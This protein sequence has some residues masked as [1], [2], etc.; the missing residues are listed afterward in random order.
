M[1]CDGER[2]VNAQHQ[3]GLTFSAS[4]AIRPPL[5]TD[6]PRGAIAVPDGT[7]CQYRTTEKTLLAPWNNFG[8]GGGGGK[9]WVHLGAR[10]VAAFFAS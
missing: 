5:A 2:K 9:L 8:T 10:T 3:A 6:M 7:D 4:C 1:F